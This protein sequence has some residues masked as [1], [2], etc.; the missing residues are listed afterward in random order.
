M[1][2]A[3]ITKGIPMTPSQFKIFSDF[4]AEF[5]SYCAS[6]NS[7]FGKALAPLQVE[8]ASKDTPSYP[9][10]NPV[11][12][13][14]ALDDIMENDDIRLIVIGDNPG[15]DE[16][17]SRNQK[18]L[19]GQSGKI[20]A[21]FFMK[22]PCFGVDFRKNAIILNKTPV[23][24]AKTKHLKRLMEHGGGQIHE[25]IQQS[26]LWMAQ[27]TV[28]L[29]IGLCRTAVSESCKP[30]VFLVGYSELKSKGLF[31]GYRDELKKRYAGHDEWNRVFVFQHFSMNRFSIDLNNY[32]KGNPELDIAQAARQLGIVHK[33]EIF[34]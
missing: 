4:R 11:V 17:L 7:R 3:S 31:I 14:T 18:Y 12:Y 15:K 23:H 8:A 32:I 26:Q 22:N 29:H 34:G 13:N 20:A 16:Q 5:R 10:E 2:Q 6:L 28:D 25:L 21:G 1:P 27:K 9:L 19:V 33:K 30:D 24:T